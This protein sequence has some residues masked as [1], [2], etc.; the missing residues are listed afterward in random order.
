MLKYD[1]E[2]TLQYRLVYIY[3]YPIPYYSDMDSRGSKN[4]SRYRNVASKNLNELGGV[5]GL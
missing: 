4:G 5:R 2:R 1:L 3:V